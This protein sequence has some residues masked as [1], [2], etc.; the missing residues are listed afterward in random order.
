MQG[1][2]NLNAG[3]T[4]C[5]ITELECRDHWRQNI[6]EEAPKLGPMAYQSRCHSV[7][8]PRFA[9]WLKKEDAASACHPHS[10]DPASC[11]SATIYDSRRGRPAF[12]PCLDSNQRYRDH[13]IDQETDNWRRIKEDEES[14]YRHW[15]WLAG[16]FEKRGGDIF[17]PRSSRDNK[18]IQ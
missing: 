9:S 6:Q 7:A 8:R 18:S 2:L 14:P 3:I 11:L 12:E 1:S 15:L 10:F 17:R 4:E 13:T 16:P 5:R